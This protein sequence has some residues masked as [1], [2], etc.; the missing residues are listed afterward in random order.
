MTASP[1]IGSV[2]G[3]PGVGKGRYNRVPR[4]TTFDNV[5]NNSRYPDSGNPSL[6]DVGLQDASNMQRSLLFVEEEEA[7][8][9][10]PSSS[11]YPQQ[12]THLFWQSPHHVPCW[13][14]ESAMETWNIIFP[15]IRHMGKFLFGI[16][17][18]TMLIVVPMVIYSAIEENRFDFAAF[19][20]AGVMVLGTLV[21]SLR[22]VY[23]HLSHWYMPQVQ[24]YVVRIVWMVPLYAVQ[25][26]LSLRFR[27][28]RI[29]IDAIR[30]LYEAFVIASFLYYLIELLGGQEALVR[31]LESKATTC[32]HLGKHTWPLNR[33]LK[34]WQLG[35]EFMLQCKHGVLQYVVVK[36][37]ATVLTYIF[38]TAGWYGQGD[39]HWNT[40]YPYLAFLL[41][42]SVM[43]ALY[44]LVM[45][46]HAVHEELQHPINWRPLGKFLCVKGVVFFTY[47][48]SV[49]IYFLQAKGFIKDTGSWSGDEIANAVIDYCICTEMVFFA[50]AHSYTFSYKEYLPSSI[51]P[52]LRNLTQN[53]TINANHHGHHSSAATTP[54]PL[55][56]EPR[57]SSSSMSQHGLAFTTTSDR[58]QQQ[59]HL[60]ANYRPPGP[61]VLDQPLNFK[62]AFWSSSIPKDTL[63]DIQRLRNGVDNVV[64]GDS[65][66][67]MISLS[68]IHAGTNKMAEDAIIPENAA[69][70]RE[71][72]ERDLEQP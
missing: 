58:Q 31:T 71:T 37:F 49:I 35:L 68:E 57:L 69:A 48:Q 65:V 10:V 62:E 23:L 56:L 4:E 12:R 24:K 32:P 54:R 41:N 50:I 47:W 63:A 21:L 18:L 36:T 1:L 8:N 38:E 45:L 67:C 59:Q 25:S 7:G 22:L 66:G 13:L 64:R 11:T 34:D 3:G 9:P 19:D 14:L 46:F 27:D 61:A 70:T 20:S 51:P 5:D 40:A 42:I 30:D 33:V 28:A 43:Y 26:F 60:N 53:A 16:T 44:V 29:Y 52:E 55:R 6:D 2:L 15:R 39:F 72:T 17:L